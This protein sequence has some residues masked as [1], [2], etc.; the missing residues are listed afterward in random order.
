[1]VEIARMFAGIVSQGQ[2]VNRV[3]VIVLTVVNRNGRD[4]DVMLVCDIVHS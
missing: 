4:L 1:M 2:R 3:K